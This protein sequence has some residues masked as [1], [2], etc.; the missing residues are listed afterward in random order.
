MDP[1]TG[2]VEKGRKEDTLQTGLS[3]P[4]ALERML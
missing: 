1:K 2:N 3:K 4:E